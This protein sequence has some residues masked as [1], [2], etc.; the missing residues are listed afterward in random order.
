VLFYHGNIETAALSIDAGGQPGEPR[1]DNDNML[2]HKNLPFFMP[3]FLT[4]K[5]EKYFFNNVFDLYIKNIRDL[6][7]FPKSGDNHGLIWSKKRA[8]FPS[9][10]VI[11]S[12]CS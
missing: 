7:P 2:A 5:S 1:A 12:S 8:H 11:S 3:M 10:P 6:L 4:S 9:S